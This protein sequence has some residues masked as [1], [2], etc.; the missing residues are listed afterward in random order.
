MEN[1]E[2]YGNSQWLHESLPIDKTTHRVV[3]RITLPMDY[4]IINI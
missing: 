2:I 1:F 4:P 3:A